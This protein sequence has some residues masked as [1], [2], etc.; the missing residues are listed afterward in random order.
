MVGIAWWC[1]KKHEQNHKRVDE[2]LGHIFAQTPN[3]L[4]WQEVPRSSFYGSRLDYGDLGTTNMIW[5]SRQRA[6]HASNSAGVTWITR[7]SNGRRP[8]SSVDNSQ[9]IDQIVASDAIEACRDVGEIIIG[10]SAAA[11]RPADRATHETREKPNPH[12]C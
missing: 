4:T 11:Q 9:I 1:M 3:S 6:K 10:Q 12:G 2:Q 7:K 8:P 5:F